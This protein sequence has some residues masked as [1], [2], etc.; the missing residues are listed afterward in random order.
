MTATPAT[1][2]HPEGRKTM[3]ITAALP[4]ANSHAHIGHI[5]EHVMMDVWGRF[6]K[7]R[8]HDCL[9][10]CA[11]DAHGTPIMISARKE[12]VSPEQIAAKYRASQ[13]EDFEAFQVV[14]D[15]F[16]STHTD[17]NR[18]MVEQFFA[19]MKAAG[20]LD[21][22]ESEQAYCETDKM[23]LPDRFVKGQCPNC[24]AYDQYGDNCEVC[25]ATYDPLEMINPKSILSGATPVPRK[26]RHQY[27]TINQFKD[28]LQGWISNHNQP[29]VA[30]K[31][32]EWF[33][34]DLKDWC[35]TRDAPYFGFKVPGF[36]DKYF[37]VWV[38]APLGYISS[39]KEYC[40]R[41]GRDYRDY[42]QN[43]KAEIYHCIGKDIIYFHSLFWPALLRTA[44]FTTPKAIVVH[45]MVT[46]GG[47]KM[48]KS[49][50][51]LISP[52]VYLKHLSPE[53]ARYYLAAKMSRTTH[54]VNWDF[55]DFQSRVNSDLVGKITNVASR[56]ASMLG[57]LDGV[58]GTMDSEGL[59]L[60]QQAKE[61]FDAAEG[62]FH[63][64]NFAKGL[65]EVREIA[66]IA[67]R[68]FDDKEP[69][70]LLKTD[71]EATKVILTTT[72]NLFRLMAIAL[73]PV[74]PEYGQRVA[75]LLGEERDDASGQP[76]RWQDAEIRLENRPIGKYEHL[77]ARIDPKTF[78]KF[79]AECT[80]PAESKAKAKSGDEA[81]A[82]VAMATM[83]DF[84]KVDLRVARI[85]SAELVAGASRLLKLSLDLGDRSIQVFSGIR[86]S[87]KPADL[88][89]RLTVCIA[90]L[91]PRKMKF[92]VSEGMVLACGQG[93]DV[94]LLSPDAGAKPGQRIT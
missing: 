10:I 19:K 59:G 84:A 6:Q 90:N 2:S 65:I 67:N 5:Y 12:G 80:G 13:L 18:Q 77:I 39:T 26:T 45:G 16:S 44:E 35:I 91:K 22:R 93:D 15:N 85:A 81:A 57:K 29:D 9:K 68:Y 25:H 11:S 20:T 61:K 53:Y 38:D 82:E 47:E 49:R 86:K 4:Y 55:D 75:R 1:P 87:Y 7:M 36:K 74:L 32:K 52:K 21:E 54:D 79:V 76:Y 37:Y 33:K 94:Y 83:E 43:P 28:Y 41:V 92:G 51:I 73:S 71:P 50:G 62:H 23:F 64:F 31:L 58:L 46:L 42:W 17:T 24:K 78:A 48:S 63:D 60:W 34:A 56:G 40:E 3:L 66:D 8:G 27:F 69:W 88:E 89:G 72:V 70:K 14:Y 30:N